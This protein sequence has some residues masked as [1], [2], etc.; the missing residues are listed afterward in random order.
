MKSFYLVGGLSSS[1]L[2]VI[3]TRPIREMRMVRA[4]DPTALLLPLCKSSCEQP[5]HN[6]TTM[7]HEL[8]LAFF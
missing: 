5:D 6:E 8:L 2:V 3:M 1:V 7:P 4:P